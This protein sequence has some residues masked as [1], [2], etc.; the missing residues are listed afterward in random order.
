M[1]TIQEHRDFYARFVV[2]SAGSSD[3]RLR[4]AF[5][6]VEREHFLGAGPWPIFAGSGYIPSVCDDPRLLYQD[7]LVALDAGRGIN[8]GQP[9]LHALCLAACAPAAG[10]RVVHVGAGTGYYTAI[11]AALVG[12]AGTVAGYEIEPDLAARARANLG[13]LPQVRI[14][15]GSGCDAALPPADLIYVS[16][17][18]THPPDSWLDALA[19]GGRLIFPLTPAAGFGCMLLVTRRGPGC[20]AA[21]VLARVRFIPCIGARDHATGRALAQALDTQSLAAVKSLHRGTTPD[22]NAWLAGRGWWLSTAE[23]GEPA[24]G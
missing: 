8:N 3:D 23:P 19:P 20:Y 18:A 2:G 15:A 1:K 9:S 22:R 16:A 13:H 11:L 10:E 21:S 14:V 17:G 6:Q 12:S 4:A 24:G 7:V 5:A